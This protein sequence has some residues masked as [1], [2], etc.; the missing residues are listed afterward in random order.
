MISLIRNILRDK[1]LQTPFSETGKDKICEF[2]FKQ[3]PYYKQFAGCS[4]EDIPFLT[5]EILKDE[6]DN[7]KSDDILHRKYFVKTSGGSTG[8]PVRILQDNDYKKHQ[9]F[10]TYQQ[11]LWC[12]YE[13]GEPM[14]HLWGSERD[15]FES[16]RSFKS[17]LIN[18]LKNLTVLNAFRM[19]EEDMVSYIRTINR[20]RPALLVAY[21]Q[22]LFE[23][24]KFAQQ[25]Q[26]DI[27]PPDAVLT[28]AGTLFPFMK[29]QI[30]TVM[31]TRVFNR[32]GTRE[33]GNIACSGLGFDDL[34]ISENNVYV[35]VVNENGQL[36]GDNEEGE[37]VV[38]SLVNYS[39]P[40]IRY[41]IGDRGVRDL[42][43]YPYPV[44]KKV[45]GRVTEVFKN[46]K[47]DIIPAEYFIH[48]IGVMLNQNLKWIKRF[49]VIQKKA[50]HIHV[51]IVSNRQPRKDSLYDIDAIVKKVMGESCQV[52]FE[53][54]DDIPLLRSGKFA[55]AIN[56]LNLRA[57]D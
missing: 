55:Y 13:F 43:S 40:L 45:A 4:F 28:S 15:I 19:S 27:K 46:I 36:C 8:E 2:A 21:V 32:Y 35:E 11:K 38:T 30:E 57:N 56:E 24:T 9:R 51:R 41:K 29:K 7:L 14:I 5:R 34:R 25:Q 26:I 47:G 37:I 48:A 54:T 3:V 49:Q 6:F 33:V 16:S 20:I 12:G 39:M 42:K 31:N 22:P 1:Y 52:T 53:Y 50:D 44:L 18:K 17:K 10:V 23:L